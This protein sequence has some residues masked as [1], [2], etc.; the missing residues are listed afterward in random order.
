MYKA[1]SKVLVYSGNGAWRFL[2]IPEKQGKEIKKL[3][4][5]FA[6]GWGSIRVEATVGRTS[7]KTSIF[8]DKKS[9]S[10]LLPLKADVR[11]AE[12]I[13]DENTVQFVFKVI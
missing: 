9:G 4:G 3:F 12:N 5:R 10:Y 1:K 8:P 11:K 6:T 2:A 7:W 13:A